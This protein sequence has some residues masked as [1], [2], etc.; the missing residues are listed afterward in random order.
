MP[1]SASGDPLFVYP[2]PFLWSSLKVFG[3]QPSGS[4]NAERL[5][6]SAKQ[7]R[8]DANIPCRRAPALQA[9]GWVAATLRLHRYDD[10]VL[11]PR[12]MLSL[13]NVL[14]GTSPLAEGGEFCLADG[15]LLLGGQPVG[16]Q[17]L[18]TVEA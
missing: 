18:C 15:G 8:T 2:K 5:C 10:A 7:N 16:A 1:T 4:H 3:R 9:S 17:L 6:L 12:V 13:Q 11:G 14:A